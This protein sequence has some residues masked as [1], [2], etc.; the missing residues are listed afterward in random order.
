MDADVWN[1]CVPCSGLLIMFGLILLIGALLLMDGLE[2]KDIS[3]FS[4]NGWAAAVPKLLTTDDGI[5]TL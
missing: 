4:T 1:Q 2:I 3:G 5:L